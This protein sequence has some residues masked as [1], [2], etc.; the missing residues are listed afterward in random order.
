[1]SA[2]VHRSDDGDGRSVQIACDGSWDM[3]KWGG[4]P[5]GLPDEVYLRDDDRLYAFE[6]S[7]VTCDA[8]IAKRE[9]AAR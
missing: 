3:P 4:Q 1:V 2:V 6:R 9:G 7:L 8:C 5:N